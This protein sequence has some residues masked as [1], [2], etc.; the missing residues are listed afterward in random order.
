[1]KFVEYKYHMLCGRVPTIEKFFASIK[2][3]ASLALGTHNGNYL[4]TQSNK[5]NLYT[6]PTEFMYVF[7]E[8]IAIYKRLIPYTAFIGW[9]L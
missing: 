7:R 1:M 6:S 8:I 9:S 2:N 5:K 3:Y 4:T